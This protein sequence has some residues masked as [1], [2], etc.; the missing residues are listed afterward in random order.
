MASIK[1]IFEMS[2]EYIK[3]L[4]LY[5]LM[6]KLVSSTSTGNDIRM[7]AIII[8]IYIIV[9]SDNTYIKNIKEKIFSYCSDDENK[10]LKNKDLEKNHRE[11]KDNDLNEDN[12][13][14]IK[15]IS[16]D[17]V[18]DIKPKNIRENLVKKNKISF[19][20]EK[21]NKNN[22]KFNL[23]E[24]YTD[25]AS[26]PYPTSIGE[27]NTDY[28]KDPNNHLFE[29]RITPSILT[30]PIFNLKNIDDVPFFWNFRISNL[31]N[32]SITNLIMLKDVSN[33]VESSTISN[34]DLQDGMY[35]IY[36]TIKKDK[37]VATFEYLKIFI[38]TDN[39]VKSAFI[40]KGLDYIKTEIYINELL[41]KDLMKDLLKGKAFQSYNLSKNSGVLDFLESILS[42]ILLPSSLIG[43]VVTLDIKHYVENKETF[44]TMFGD[45]TFDF[46][47][48]NTSI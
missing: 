11:F 40:Q 47:C 36:I 14:I 26:N 18:K 17:D 25:L 38:N 33:W 23:C 19:D 3:L 32:K 6:S 28:I 4:F 7:I 20:I 48:L 37:D 8:I 22:K 21:K 43:K 39:S 46:N 13:D 1:K 42:L 12:E 2:N 44:A 31:S 16:E 9:N 35:P 5:F 34:E 15:D 45:S 41:S 10:D 24:K 30:T 29:L 27:I